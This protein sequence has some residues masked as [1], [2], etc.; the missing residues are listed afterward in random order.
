MGS[1]CTMTYT[2]DTV[3]PQI[4]E[5]YSPLSGGKNWESCEISRHVQLTE[6]TRIKRLSGVFKRVSHPQEERVRKLGCQLEIIFHGLLTLE[7]E[8]AT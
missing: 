3:F 1:E 5:W 6:F 2:K 8:K 4:H 7:V